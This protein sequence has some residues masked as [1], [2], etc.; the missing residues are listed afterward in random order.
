MNN[1]L[2]IFA[3]AKPASSEPELMD[4]SWSAYGLTKQDLYQHKYVSESYPVA[5]VADEVYDPT[6]NNYPQPPHL[7]YG[8]TAPTVLDGNNEELARVDVIPAMR[9]NHPAAVIQ[10]HHVIKSPVRQDEELVISMEAAFMILL[11]E[12]ETKTESL[13]PI[14]N[15][16]PELG[17]YEQVEAVLVRDDEGE[18]FID[19]I[20]HYPGFIVERD[21]FPFSQ[22]LLNDPR[23]I[24]RMIV[25]NG[26]V[27]FHV[28]GQDIGTVGFASSEPGPG[29]L[30]ILGPLVSE[31]GANIAQIYH[32]RVDRGTVA[33]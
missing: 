4:Y 17:S 24:F 16:R 31:Q 1:R 18:C 32:V 11:P 29:H 25:R 28:N 26:S 22:W 5:Q 6:R 12:D 21:R 20:R 2:I 9:E 30:T 33:E 3:G 7:L 15:W 23:M 14:F 10:G 19:L 27:T 13:Q 8:Y